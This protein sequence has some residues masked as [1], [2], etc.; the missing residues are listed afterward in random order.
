[1]ATA[2]GGAVS[3]VVPTGTKGRFV[4][5][6]GQRALLGYGTS[7][8]YIKRARDSGASDI[9]YVTWVATTPEAPYPFAPPWGGPLIDTVILRKV[10]NP[11]L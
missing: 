1:M 9:R 8:V 4:V 2:D 3:Y 5:W 7:Y 10:P 11:N 6:N